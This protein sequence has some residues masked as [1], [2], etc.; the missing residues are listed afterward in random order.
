MSGPQRV[1]WTDM[2]I[3]A[4]KVRHLFSSLD[5]GIDERR[6]PG[7]LYK[8]YG[9]PR[10][11][12]AV[13]ALLGIP[14]D[15]PSEADI[16]CDDL[17]DSGRT[18]AEWEQRFPTKPFVALYDKTKEPDLGWLVFPWEE[19]AEGSIEDAVVRLLQFMGEDP[20]REGLLKTPA[21]VAR[22]L[23]E[24]TRGY[25]Q[26]PRKILS[27]QF[28]VGCDEMVVVRDIPFYSLCEHHLLPFHGTVTV[29]YIPGKTVVGLSKLARLVECYAARLQ[30]QERMTEQIAQAMQKHLGAEGSAC[31]VEAVHLCM[32]MRGV[33]SGGATIT[34]CLLGHM[35]SDGQAR[36]EFLSLSRSNG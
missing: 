18:R 11:G 13:A 7:M 2:M 34:S 19:T 3:R 23:T 16:I 28:N 5:G 21:R 12:C 30:V 24:M 32:G 9:V 35:R 36:S 17:I 33:R 26:D 1:T 14:V 10:G 27:A 8:V 22:A 31:V 15:D 29:G 20:E 6:L 4:E 25:Q